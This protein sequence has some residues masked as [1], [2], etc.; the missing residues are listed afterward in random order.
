MRNKRPVDALFPKTRRDILA[1]T[2]GQP[3]RWWYLSELAG[4]LSTSPSSL[5]RELRS[6]AASGL[7]RRRQ[8]GRR[9]YFQAESESPIYAELR[10]IV[11][12]TMGVASALQDVMRKLGDRVAC[13]FLHGSVARREEHALS[14]AD[15]VV[16][17][18]IG[19]SDLSPALRAL[20]KKFGREFNAT[21]YSPAEFRRKAKEGNHFVLSVL[22]GDKV[23]L[24]GDE[25]EL[26]S[27]AGRP[28]GA[29]A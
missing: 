6:L 12:K 23:F 14:D 8:D 5:Q 10:G 27:L 21:C 7:L 13:A 16:I 19:L 3:D 1:A 4:H 28:L 22:A 26:E 25:G 24:K 2:Y 9:T 11:T 15:V 18:S 20:E 17:G 29:G